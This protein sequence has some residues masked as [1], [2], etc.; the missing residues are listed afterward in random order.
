MLTPEQREKRKGGLGGSDIAAILG[1]DPY[2]T[3]MQLWLEKTGRAEPED[4]S[5]KAPVYWGNVLEAVI[6]DE[7]AKITGAKVHR[8]NETL[9]HPKFPWL[10]GHIDR[11]VVGLRKL[12]E[13]K[14]AGFFMA[15]EWGEPGTDHVPERYIIQVQHYLALKDYEEADIAALIAG[16]D[17]RIHPIV[18]DEALIQ[19]MIE[20]ANEFWQKNVLED[21]PPEP[22]SRLESEQ[23]H[24]R[25]SGKT[26]EAPPEVIGVINEYKALKNKI[27]ALEQEKKQREA[28]IT[29][30]IGSASGIRVADKIVATW[31]AN[32]NGSRVL[33]LC[34]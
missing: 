3:A 10:L 17:F 32:I 2:K 15:K 4:I 24:P 9:Q 16:S 29:K 21:I 27:A 6:A 30:V 31:K 19:T 22:T 23:L 13:C 5:D 14:T 18:R 8:V 34:A 25:D 26:E 1:V 12:L 33:R 20:R 7:Y 28:Q 11:R